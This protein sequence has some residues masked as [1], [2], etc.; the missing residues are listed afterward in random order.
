[1]RRVPDWKAHVVA[2]LLVF[3]VIALFKPLS[4]E[5]GMLAM[6]VMVF[7]SVLPDLDYP[8]S[9]VRQVMGIAL[10]LAFS[11]MVALRADAALEMKILM[12]VVVWGLVY[13][14]FSRLPLRHRGRR[15]LHRWGAG[16]VFAVIVGVAS[17]LAGFSATLALFALLGYF[18]HLV[19][20]KAGKRRR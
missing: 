5:Y 7:S 8:R 19:V 12:A 3:A 10:A 9:V 2:A 18:L 16:L 6:V 13:F 4:L 17:W 1:M 20:D 11:V 14:G 15:S